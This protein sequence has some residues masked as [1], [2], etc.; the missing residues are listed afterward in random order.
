MKDALK[1]SRPRKSNQYSSIENDLFP[2]YNEEYSDIYQNIL[3]DSKSSF[4]QNLTDRVILFIKSKELDYSKDSL[5]KMLKYFNDTIYQHDYL[6]SKAAFNQVKAKMNP[7]SHSHLHPLQ[8]KADIQYFKSNYI[9]HCKESKVAL[10][11]CGNSLIQFNDKQTS[12]SYILCINCKTIYKPTL[13]KLQCDNCDDEFYTRL[14]TLKESN[15]QY[16][17]AT[18]IK[19]HCNA[20]INDKMKCLQCKEILY[21]DKGSNIIKCF[22]CK[23]TT[24]PENI[25]WKCIICGM[26]FKSG[27]KDYNP[28][29]YKIMKLSVKEALINKHYA[30]PNQFP[31]CEYTRIEMQ[32]LVFVH[33][34]NCKGKMLKGKMN[35]R[36]IVVCSK[37]QLINYYDCYS[38]KCFKCQKKFKIK[39]LGDS[40]ISKSNKN[41]EDEPVILRQNSMKLS[42]AKS[43]PPSSSSLMH[44]CISKSSQK[45]IQLYHKKSSLFAN[46]NDDNLKQKQQQQNYQYQHKLKQI[47]P[48]CLIEIIPKDTIEKEGSLA[49]SSIVKRNTQDNF[50]L[51]LHQDLESHVSLNNLNQFKIDDNKVNK[52]PTSPDVLKNNEILLSFGSKSTYHSDKNSTFNNNNNNQSINSP[53]QFDF[54]ADDYDIISQ[55]GQG[56]FGQIYL[57]ESPKTK[58]RFAMK[59]IVASSN[60]EIQKRT[61]EY[62]LL[63]SLS[64]SKDNLAIVSVIAIQTK[65]LDPTT[66]VMYIL[67]E[68]ASC[69]WDNEIIER[70][71]TQH[72]YTEEELLTHLSRLISTSAELQK[73]NISHRDIKPANILLFKKINQLKMSDFDESK[74]HNDSI[75]QTIRGTELFMSPMLITAYKNRTTSSLE[76]NLYK[77]DLFSLGLCFIYAAALTYQPIYEIRDMNDSN[78]IKQIVTKYLNKNYR[79]E[80]ITLLLTMIELD[81]QKR[82][83]FVQFENYV[84]MYI[85]QLEVIEYELNIHPLHV[86][87]Q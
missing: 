54:D 8:V 58:E 61:K 69:D 62:N 73:K 47:E 5:E 41:E 20:V 2:I 44:H 7:S 56:T 13:I 28:L 51:S 63:I 83:D 50:Y 35:K 11:T 72:Y 78:K 14:I 66:F 77:S 4:L 48:N 9:K 42:S 79:K 6:K 43:N 84:V 31:C 52:T 19:Y 40:N 74:T 68:L 57:V 82:F 55:I 70:S 34:S 17:Q 60:Q 10:H 80:F 86:V 33:K 36:D 21:Y 59:K 53:T 22:N 25:D 15:E 76:H 3:I 75:K 24:Q 1:L 16:H 23:F 37:C 39:I 45:I 71:Q 18:W 27:A 26:S 30:V 32:N 81:E 67:M 85:N 65:Q 49:H 46:K 64:N 29:D 12:T 38:W 87:P